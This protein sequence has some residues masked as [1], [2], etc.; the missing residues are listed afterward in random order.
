MSLKA[1]QMQNH[2]RKYFCYIQHLDE[3]PN[4]DKVKVVGSNPGTIYWMDIFFTF[5]CCKNCND[6]C[7]KRPTINE[8][9]AGVG[10][11]F[12]KNILFKPR[13]NIFFN[14]SDVAFA[15]HFRGQF[16]KKNYASI[17][18]GF[19][20]HVYFTWNGNSP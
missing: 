2:S 12:K 14:E 10:P 4:I 7:L 13:H 20:I 11:F 16:N 19:V 6:V 5:I 15:N 17:N 8:K 3:P 9:E 1:T 18:Y